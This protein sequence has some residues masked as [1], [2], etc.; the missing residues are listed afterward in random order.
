M[1]RP[2]VKNIV[3]LL[4]GLALLVLAGVLTASVGLGLVPKI[5]VW[6][7]LLLLFSLEV[8]SSGWR[9]TLL[10]ARLGLLLNVVSMLTLTFGKTLLISHGWYESPQTMGLF[11]QLQWVL[12][13]VP[14]LLQN[15]VVRHNWGVKI[16]PEYE[17]LYI[18]GGNY[19]N[20]LLQV[21]AVT[22]LLWLG[23]ALL[24]VVRGQGPDNI[25]Y[26]GER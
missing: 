24:K 22:S 15:L 5:C 23:T 7:G 9:R 6:V 19:A 21:T 26:Q 1:N 8:R 12:N 3:S 20:L 4:F 2:L 13:T 10:Y 11:S 16:F 14:T 25:Q 17:M 18:L